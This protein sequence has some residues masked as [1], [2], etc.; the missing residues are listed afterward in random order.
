MVT[1]ARG[2]SAFLL[3]WI[4]GS[5]F[6][7]CRRLAGRRAAG[8]PTADRPTAGRPAT[9]R[10]TVCITKRCATTFQIKEMYSFL[11]CFSMHRYK[12][13]KLAKKIDPN[14]FARAVVFCYFVFKQ[15]LGNPSFFCN[16]GFAFV[17]IL[18]MF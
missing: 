14:K 2:P 6:F 5:Y 12:N 4:Y 9:G 17:Q 11:Y 8:R 1:G 13:T 3:T 10:P 16:L 15:I 18:K 7:E